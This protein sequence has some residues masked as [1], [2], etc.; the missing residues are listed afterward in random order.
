LIEF[1]SFGVVARD[2]EA[3]HVNRL[4]AEGV[5]LSLLAMRIS[6]L[7]GLGD[8]LEAWKF[9]TWFIKKSTVMCM[10]S[11]RDWVINPKT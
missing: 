3:A 5:Q 2:L 8:I 7:L 9:P 6:F 1:Q 11:Y 10:N 4:A